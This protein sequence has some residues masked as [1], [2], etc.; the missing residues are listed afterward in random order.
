MSRKNGK[1]KP[2]RDLPI[3]LQGIEKI[4]QFLATESKSVVSIRNVSGHTGLSMRV[5]KNILFQLEN[6]NQ[7]ERVLEKNNILPKWRITKFGKRVIKEAGDF[8]SSAIFP[9]REDELAHNI[10]VPSKIEEIRKECKIKQESIITELNTLQTDLSKTL[11]PIINANNLI[12]EDLIGY[13]IKRVKFLRQITSNFPGDPLVG[14]SLKKMD[15]KKI[16]VSKEEE[17]LLLAEIHFFY[18]VILNELKRMSDFVNKLAQFLENEA[19][20]NGYSIAKD[21]RDELRIL[22]SL[23]YQRENLTVNKHKISTEDLKQ[24]LKGNINPSILN[25][26]IEPSLSAETRTKAVEEFVLKIVENINKGKFQFDDHNYDIRENI[27]LITLYN[28]ILDEKPGLNLTIEQLERVIN[29]L[30][31]NG[32]IPG[33]T[34]IQEDEDHYLKVVQLKTHDISEDESKLISYSLKVD[35]ITLADVLEKFSWNTEKGTQILDN[36]TTLGIFKH[37]KSYLY[38]NQWYVVSER[39]I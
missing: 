27:P 20:S 19:Y 26:L 13:M 12:F 5:V 38:G 34:I 9:S 1:T 25:K 3:S 14:V 4:L 11:G 28:I 22:S 16:K 33:M 37:S 15:E 23:L 29:S 35:K 10:T 30:A 32:Y 31:D 2:T 6:F 24:I 36:L 17:K 18:S 39:K 8:E 21:L 7:V